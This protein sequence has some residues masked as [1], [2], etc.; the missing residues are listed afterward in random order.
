MAKPIMYKLIIAKINMNEIT[1][2]KTKMF[3]MLAKPTM[4]KLTIVLN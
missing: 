4:A 3:K 2:A 1:M